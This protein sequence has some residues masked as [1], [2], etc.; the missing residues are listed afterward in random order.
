MG[1]KVEWYSDAG[2]WLDGEVELGSF[3]SLTEMVN[4]LFASWWDAKLLSDS[5][6]GV[7]E[8]PLAEVLTPQLV[9]PC[10]NKPS[11]QDKD[12]VFHCNTYSVEKF[13]QSQDTEIK[14]DYSLDNYQTPTLSV[15]QVKV[16]ILY[17][18]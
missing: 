11:T 4:V 5:L 18:F 6:C 12:L 16:L 10:R 14:Q 9:I 17:N 2:A 15:K 1:V 8:Q 3:H 7:L 13:Y